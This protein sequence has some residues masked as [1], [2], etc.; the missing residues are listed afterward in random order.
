[1]PGTRDGVGEIETF[2]GV[3]EVAHEVAAAQFAVG[4]DLEA[5][6]L[7]P[8]EHPRDVAVFDGLKG[9]STG[10]VTARFQQLG[11][12]QEA[13]NVIRSVR[14]AHCIVSS[15]ATVLR[16]QI[17]LAGE[18]YAVRASG[19]LPMATESRVAISRTNCTF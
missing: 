15:K 7:L 13:S 9:L 17:P 18:A 3:G 1:V 14:R 16:K 5:E 2:D 12:A 4:A 6:F 11:G 8:G 19:S 10:A